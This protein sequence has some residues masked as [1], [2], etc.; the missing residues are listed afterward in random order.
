MDREKMRKL[1]AKAVV[2]IAGAG[3]LGSNCSAS[4]VRAGVHRLIIADFDK[5]TRSNLDRQYYFLS[6][7]GR[8][9]VDALKENLVAI[10]PQAEIT[11][12]R[13]RI[14]PETAGRIFA[15]CQVIVEAFDAAEAKVMLIETCLRAFPE[16]HIVAASGLAGVGRFEAIKVMH[17][18]R[19]HLCGDFESE[20]GPL[21]P[22]VAPR[23]GIV[24]NLQAD[25]VLE[26]LLASQ[27]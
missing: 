4:L 24:A 15:G 2:G 17:R 6:Q 23:V 16:T 11:T 14:D 10:D 7:V 22:P 8:F 3:G 13:S 1:L 9:K 18:G 21:S 19:L 26:L 25:T 12:H 27:R 5:V 20:T